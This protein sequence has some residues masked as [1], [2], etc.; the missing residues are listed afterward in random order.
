MQVTSNAQFK[1]DA[2]I[3][4][5]NYVDR[6]KHVLDSHQAKYVAITHSATYSPDDIAT[7]EFSLGRELIEA[8]I[9]RIRA[10]RYIMVVAQATRKLNMDSLQR[11]F[12]GTGAAFASKAEIATLFPDCDPTAIPPFGHLYGVETY[13]ARELFS[14]HDVTFCV[15]SHA[16]RIRMNF[17][18]YLRIAQP[19]SVL[20]VETNARYLGQI[21]SVNPE[22]RR[23]KLSTSEVCMLGFS[24][25]NKNFSASKL[26]GI[27][28]WV[29]RN[30]SRCVI[31]V[32]DSIHRI[33]LEVKGMDP[34]RALKKAL[35]IGQDVVHEET[36]LLERYSDECHFDLRLC[37][38]IFPQPEC[39]TYYEKLRH[40]L[41]TDERFRASARSFA[42]VFVG[43]RIQQ[44]PVRHEYYVD[45]SCTYLMEELAI[46]A[47]VA[48]QG[49]SVF[50]YPGALTLLQEITEGLHPAA[51]DA[52]RNL[53]SVSLD[54]K[55]R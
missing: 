51:P 23:A 8:S 40:L 32:G 17:Q 27:A 33:T 9:V 48:R 52:L 36:R 24:L 2:P 54:L 1:S 20:D 12:G 39:Q 28:E 47:D 41:K 25:Q 34:E 26:S 42:D 14:L 16:L 7:G 43:R 50:V 22:T 6:I 46:M 10:N 19:H 53:T 4:A 3:A 21:I 11:I 15:Q 45:M 55:R 31:L 49:V 35:A 5:S 13:F 37:S 38:D 18:E 29:S 30:F 44:D